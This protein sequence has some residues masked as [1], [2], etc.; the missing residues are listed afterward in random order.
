MTEPALSVPDPRV[1][2][3]IEL[4]SP[5]ERAL[6]ALAE[7]SLGADS[8][9]DADA[10]DRELRSALASA[11]ELDGAKL[12]ALLEHAPSVAVTRHLWRALDGV[13]R[14][15]PSQGAGVGV[16]V[17]ALPIVIIAGIAGS[18]DQCS[19]SGVLQD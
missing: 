7:S 4:A 10:C 8:R 15:A 13:W 19:L 14:E 2:L 5:E 1:F 12:A 6:Y 18:G 11:L 9:Q 17:F 16:T 3:P